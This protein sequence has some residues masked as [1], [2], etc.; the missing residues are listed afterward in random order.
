MTSTARL[1][2]TR[3]ATASGRLSL[4]LDATAHADT[5]AFADSSGDSAGRQMDMPTKN[6]R[7]LTLRE[8]WGQRAERARALANVTETKRKQWRDG[9]M[10]Q[11]GTK[12]AAAQAR[13]HR[14]PHNAAGEPPCADSAWKHA[15]ATSSD[16]A[17]AAGSPAAATTKNSGPESAKLALVARYALRIASACDTS[18]ARR[19][20]RRHSEGNQTWLADAST[21]RCVG[22]DRITPARDEGSALPPSLALAC[23]R[24][25][26][27]A[28]SWLLDAPIVGPSVSRCRV[29]AAAVSGQ[30]PKAWQCCLRPQAFGLADLANRPLRPLRAPAAMYAQDAVSCCWS[31]SLPLG[32]ASVGPTPCP[33]MPGRRALCCRRERRSSPRPRRGMLP[34]PRR[35]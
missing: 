6:S 25:E 27:G 35:P 12:S 7:A 9:R 1:A 30:G 8:V 23:G 22:S 32:A 19:A 3:P 14:T 4:S 28:L 18:P 15:A 5:A 34:S 33:G 21:V 2:A 10:R 17:A 20:G 13:G 16:D 26:K 31:A 11:Q 24:P 29:A